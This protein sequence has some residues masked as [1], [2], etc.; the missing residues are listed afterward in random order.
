MT[1]TT[2][3]SDSDS[4]PL[5][6]GSNHRS[7][8]ED[9]EGTFHTGHPYRHEPDAKTR[10]IVWGSLSFIFVAALVVLLFFQDLLRD[11]FYPWLGLLPGNTT[12]A[13]LA[14]LDNA[15]VIVR[16]AVHHAQACE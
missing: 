7:L 15:P 12:L 6:Q 5:I 2:N 8:H 13:A 16:L 11:S 1:S 10:G 4:S 3:S 9:S 14:I